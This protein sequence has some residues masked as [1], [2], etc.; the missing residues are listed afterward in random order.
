M[1]TLFFTLS[2][3][4]LNLW[5]NDKYYGAKSTEAILRF[6][7][8]IDVEKGLSAAKKRELI[9]LQVQHLI[10][11]F[12]APT[13][14]EKYKLPGV[15]GEQY[16]IT[17]AR[18]RVLN[19][20]SE[21]NYRYE[22]KVNFHRNA[23]RHSDEATVVV[24]LPFNPETIY[25]LGVVRGKN[26]CT[27]DTYNAPGDFFY[28]WDPDKEGC[29]LK[30][31]TEDVLRINA[32][33]E[34]L[35][36]TTS[37]Y[38]EYD[39]LYNKE[40][41]KLAVFVGHIDNSS[42]RDLGAYAYRGLRDR[43]KSELALELKSEIRGVNEGKNQLAKFEGFTK[44]QLGTEQ[45]IELTLLLADTEVDSDDPTFHKEIKK[46]FEEA[47]VIGYDGHSGLG[48]NLD[49][50]NLPTINFTR[51]YQIYF[52]NGCSSYPYFNRQYFAA[53]PGGSRNLEIITAGLPTLTTTSEDNMLAFLT[54]FIRGYQT[55][56]QN[57]MNRLEASNGDE[58][59]Y[60]MGVNG[61]EDNRFRPR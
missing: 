22:G 51:D 13:Y 4:S 56:W 2:F 60:L 32:K 36:N 40:V 9:D 50:N 24:H 42:S 43:L 23:F 46:A 34:R 33:L 6:A 58:S 7:G 3:L 20:R 1:K 26:R 17:L 41:L 59:T 53:K 48:G 27:D 37:T 52:F 47:D 30:G 55:S 12:Q 11:H 31:N 10:G 57:I 14:L 39:R 35:A 28:F 21:V 16:K 45:K 44:T 19:D 18:E 8:K 5:A 15:P 25:D 61:D 54:P 29:P 38:P 49:L